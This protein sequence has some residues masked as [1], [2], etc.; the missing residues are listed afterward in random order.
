V[1]G[2]LKYQDGGLDS[3]SSGQVRLEDIGS[4]SLETAFLDSS[5]GPPHL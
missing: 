4:A 2:V 3:V 1:E 5:D